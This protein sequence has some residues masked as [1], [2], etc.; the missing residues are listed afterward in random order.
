[1]TAEEKGR[2][3]PKSRI[4]SLSDLIFGL[5]LSIGA[6][7]LIGQPPTD[8]GQLLLAILYYAFSFFILIRV[9]YTYT[10]TMAD[11]RLETSRSLNL[12][13]ALLFLVSIEPFL[14]NQLLHSSLS[15]TQ[16]VSIV[17]ALDLGGLFGIQAFLADS[18]LKEKNR[19]E[20]VL[21][22]YRLLRNA[23]IVSVAIFLA[24]A[25]PVFWTWA[26]RI[27]SETVIPL[28]FLLWIVPLT[29]SF[30]RRLWERKNKNSRGI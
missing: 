4:E 1:M 2:T 11:L 25:L 6:L 3:T 23:E 7:T 24:S 15:L 16:N 30:F 29:L 22:H 10:K 12:N 17:Y 28:R 5:A 21:Q 9:W 20:N 19:P 26:I 13:I 14:F 27:N 8:F 18:I